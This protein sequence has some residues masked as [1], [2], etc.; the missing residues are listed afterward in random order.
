[1]PGIEHSG[2]SSRDIENTQRGISHMVLSV[3]G[4]NLNECMRFKWIFNKLNAMWG[5]YN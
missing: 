2:I 4:I 1:M 3:H 5:V